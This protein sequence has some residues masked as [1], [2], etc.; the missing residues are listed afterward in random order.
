MPLS[1]NLNK[2]PASFLALAELRD[3]MLPHMMT[4]HDEKAAHSFRMKVYGFTEALRAA[5]HPMTQ[6]M[7]ALLFQVRGPA[8]IISLRDTSVSQMDEILQLV[9]DGAPSAAVADVT[10]ELKKPAFPTASDEAVKAFMGNIAPPV[11]KDQEK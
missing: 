8:V 10:P 1:K 6:R 5:Q 2:Y 7:D 11:D 4:F 9:R 3:E